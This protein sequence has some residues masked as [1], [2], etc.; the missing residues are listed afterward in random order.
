MTSTLLQSIEAKEQLENILVA[1][2]K[3]LPNQEPILKELSKYSQSKDQFIKRL[4]QQWYQR[5]LPV[6]TELQIRQMNSAYY[7]EKAKKQVSNGLQ[8]KEMIDMD[9]RHW[10]VK[11]ESEWKG[12]N[13]SDSVY[14]DTPLLFE[15]DI[16]YEK[17]FQPLV[18]CDQASNS[19]NLILSL[20]KLIKKGAEMCL[21]DSNWVNLFLTFARNHMPNDHQTLSKYSDSI[22]TLFE[23]IVGSCN[24]DAEIGKI[25]TALANITRKPGESIQT[26]LYRFKSLYEM[27]IS[28]NLPDL[29]SEKIKIR[30]DNY[31]CNIAKNLVTPNTGKVLADYVVIRQQRDETVNLMKLC[32]VITTHES[33]NVADRIQHIMYLPSSA[34]RLDATISAASNVEELLVATAAL[35]AGGSSTP[36]FRRN[37]RPSTPDHRGGHRARSPYKQSGDNGWRRGRNGSVHTPGGSIHPPPYSSSSRR[38]SGAGDYIRPYSGRGRSGNRQRTPGYNQRRSNDRQGRSGDRKS[39]SGD[40]GGSHRQRGHTPGRGDNRSGGNH[41]NDKSQRSTGN[42]HGSRG[43]SDG[44]RSATPKQ[45]HCMRCGSTNHLSKDCPVY[46][47]Y[48]GEECRVCGLMHNTKYHRERS[49]S[50]RRNYPQRSVKSHHV[51]LES[52]KEDSQQATGVQI[53]TPQYNSTGFEN[54]FGGKN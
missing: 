54:I 34:S 29:D 2:N 14:Y 46:P 40:R 6:F 23:Q 21:S 44:R 20:T 30:A 41:W 19:V 8:G 43:R 36:Q 18:V 25:R 33:G 15:G 17:N 48:N 39:K 42:Y 53:P 38:N 31:S 16:K 35:P 1:I 47:Y 9:S 49:T 50:N 7:S 13:A 12:W 26:P 11:S 3:A 51:G 45:D 32:N 4:Q 28:I 10:I 24:A 52:S 5:D 22:D 27:L 37:S